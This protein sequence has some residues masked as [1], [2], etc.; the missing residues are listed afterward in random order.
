MKFRE[1]NAV[2]SECDLCCIQSEADG[3]VA[4]DESHESDVSV[5][6]CV[7]TTHPACF[8]VEISLPVVSAC[9]VNLSK[10]EVTLFSKRGES[11][12]ARLD[13]STEKTKRLEKESQV[14]LEMQEDQHHF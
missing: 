10:R 14:C 8:L 9:Q 2:T 13:F 7:D 11:V 6:D 3:F 4:P 5:W 1:C 12:S